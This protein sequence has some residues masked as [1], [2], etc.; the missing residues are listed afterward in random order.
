MNQALILNLA[1][2]AAAVICSVA[3]HNPLALVAMML[4]KDLP[5]GLML[6]QQAEEEEEKEESK[7]IGFIQ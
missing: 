2:I 3:L 7:P 4:M 1:V 5:Y 6:P